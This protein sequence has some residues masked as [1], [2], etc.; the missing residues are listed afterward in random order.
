MERRRTSS[1]R[2]ISTVR[3]RMR[4][5]DMASV[6]VGAGD[7]RDG[8]AVSAA[9]GACLGAS[10]REGG[11]RAGREAILG[12]A[13][14]VGVARTTVACPLESRGFAHCLES[15]PRCRHLRQRTSLVQSR[16]TWPGSRHRKKRPAASSGDGLRRALGEAAGKRG[17][18]DVS[19]PCGGVARIP[20]CRWCAGPGGSR[21]AGQ[22]TPWPRRGHGR[23][24]GMRRS[25]VGL[26]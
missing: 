2:S 18:P 19:R 23:R 24:R 8:A 25:Q 13:A 9:E 17:A 10:A 12:A 1:A 15:W 16:T 20:R 11:S 14:T 5:D 21:S 3:D 4:R 6:A 7:A 22:R 26:W